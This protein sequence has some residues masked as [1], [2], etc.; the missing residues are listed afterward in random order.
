MMLLLDTGLGPDLDS[1]QCCLWHKVPESCGAVSYT[2]RE[3]ER[4]RERVFIKVMEYLHHIDLK[5]KSSLLTTT[6]N[7]TVIKK[8]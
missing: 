6:R 2:G 1:F 7:A 4:E 8:Q 5:H 3:R